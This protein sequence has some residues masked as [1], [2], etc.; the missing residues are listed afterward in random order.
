[1]KS[2]T[3]EN[4]LK[5]L[6]MLSQKNM[7]VSVNEL[8]KELD[9]TMPTVTA[10]MKRF[11]KKNWVIYES[12]KPIRLSEEGKKEAAMIVRKHRL[13]EM[14]LVDVMGFGWEFVHEVAEQVEHIK[15]EMFFNKMDKMLNYPKVDPHGSPIPDKNGEIIRLD[16]V[17]LSDCQA[18]DKVIFR[19]VENSTEDFLTFL[20]DKNLSLQ[21]TIKVKS[22]EAFDQS[23]VIRYDKK[24]FVFS[25]KA[26]EMMLVEKLVDGDS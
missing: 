7:N 6:F 25:K 9:I 2:L 15:S 18:N 8:S 20:N 14:F 24:N 21:T 1:M 22:I 5:A 23:M 10:M 16:Y 19:A 3:E 12:Y 26:C 11:A 13:T 17:R 4:Y